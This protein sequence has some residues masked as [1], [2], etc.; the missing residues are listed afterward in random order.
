MAKQQVLGLGQEQ[1]IRGSFRA[2]ED[3]ELAREDLKVALQPGIDHGE[4]VADPWRRPGFEILRSEAPNPRRRNVDVYRLARPFDGPA[5]T[6]VPGR[7]SDFTDRGT[8]AHRVALG[9]P[10]DSRAPRRPDGQDAVVAIA[11]CYAGG[12]ELPLGNRD[13]LVIGFK[14]IN[15]ADAGR[16]LHRG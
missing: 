14:T 12:I 13:L 7:V 4:E 3:L 16:L 10:S 8:L 11:G 2:V 9:A 5:G 15:K 1:Q 6:P